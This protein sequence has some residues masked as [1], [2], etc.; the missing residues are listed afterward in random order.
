MRFLGRNFCAVCSEAIIERIHQ[1]IQHAVEDIFP[2][3]V[4]LNA[5]TAP[6]DFNLQL[7]TPEPNTLKVVWYLNGDAL[8]TNNTPAFRLRPSDLRPDINLL[9][10]SVEDTTQLV[11]VDNH[12]SLHRY[13]VTWTI[14][15]NLTNL[16]TIP[17]GGERLH[18]HVFPNPASDWLQVHLNSQYAKDA[19]L[20]LYDETGRVLTVQKQA[21]L[22]QD[23]QQWT[24]NLQ[25]LPAGVYSV[26]VYVNGVALA[27][28]VL[29]LE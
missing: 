14:R 2:K 17:S 28:K 15:N 10:A 4:M 16:E 20:E 22:R 24:L 18:L 1:L 7:L 13:V 11:R 6:M 3:E 5:P 12:G 23:Q 25:S 8:A 19:Q 26:K 21:T 9:A 29:K 27:T